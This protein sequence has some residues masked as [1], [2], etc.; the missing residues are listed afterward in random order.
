MNVTL[1]YPDG[2]IANIAYLTQGDPRYPKETVEIFGE[3]RVA[4]LRDFSRSELWFDGRRRVRR[5]MSIDK[6]QKR[7][8]EAF[9]HAVKLAAEM[10]IPTRSLIAS[11]AATFAAT[12]S[13]VTRCVEN[14]DGW[15]RHEADDAVTHPRTGTAL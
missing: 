9:V 14:V 11:T 15:M 12:R 5:S 3:G 8:L 10:P 2:S 1:R 7:E 6:G 13:A 4:R